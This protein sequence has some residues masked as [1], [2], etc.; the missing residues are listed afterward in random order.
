[1]CDRFHHVWQILGRGPFLALLSPLPVRKR[2][3]ESSIFSRLDQ[4]NKLFIDLPQYRTKRLL[5]LQKSSAGFVLNTY[6]ACE[7]KTKLKW[8]LIPKK[9]DFTIAKLI[10]KGLL[11]ERAIR[12]R[13]LQT[14]Y[15][16]KLIKYTTF[17]LV[18]AIW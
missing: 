14:F 16:I 9:I 6:A 13:K 1:M 15:R 10:F 3:T 2:L 12:S 5:K 8:P 17:A 18:W 4:C 11:K 7:D